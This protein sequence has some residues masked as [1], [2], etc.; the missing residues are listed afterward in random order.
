MA[1]EPGYTYSNSVAT[2]SAA[3]GKTSISAPLFDITRTATATGT[4]TA[5]TAEAC[6]GV[7]IINSSGNTLFVIANSG[8]AVSIPANSGFSFNVFN[9]SQLQISGSGAIGYTVSK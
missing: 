6:Q 1:L 5:L 2:A 3:D 8:S 7:T 4:A 9:T